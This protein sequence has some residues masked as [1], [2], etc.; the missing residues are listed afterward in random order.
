MDEV[1]QN[2][3]K[4]L[5]LISQK[6]KEASEIETKEKDPDLKKY[7]EE[8]LDDLYKQKEALE[9]SINLI[10][11][12][13]DPIQE[14]RENVYLNS[15]ILEVRAGTGGDEAGLFA[16]ELYNMYLKFA[17][18]KGW[19]VS[20]IS[21]TTGLPGEIRNVSAEMKG[22][23]AYTLLKNESGVHRV[24][25]VPVTENAGRIHTSTATVAILPVVSQG[26]VDLKPQDIKVDFFHASG[27]GGQNVNKVETA[28]RITH[29]PT[30]IVVE[31]QEQRHQ[32]QNREKAMQLLRSRLY[33]MMKVQH[34]TKVDELRA[35]QIGNAD[36]SEKIRTYN[37]PQDR[38]TDHRLKASWHNMEAKLA[39]DL[40]EVI[41]ETSKL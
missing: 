6:I 21:K 3:K 12:E 25:R 1:I 22:P 20:E 36:R 41:T 39:G 33:E 27:H 13:S 28:V 5:D 35:D 23:N 38:I 29:L 7:A 37:F 4:D 14:N 9:K 18:K 16:R 11:G 32:A 34:K 19:K 15:A 26:E 30:G 31:S 2:L 17:E 40:E 10:S 24:Q 8:E